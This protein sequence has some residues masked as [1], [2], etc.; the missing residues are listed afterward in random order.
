[1]RLTREFPWQGLLLP[2]VT[3]LARKHILQVAHVKI[4]CNGSGE[5]HLI[6]RC[7]LL[8]CIFRTRA[9]KFLAAREMRDESY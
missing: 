6:S 7:R 4:V 1:M 5:C 2:P 9:T 8:K 3:V